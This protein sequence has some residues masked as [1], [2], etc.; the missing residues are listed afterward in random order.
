MNSYQEIS[1]V[2]NEEEDGFE[3]CIEAYIVGTEKENLKNFLASNMNDDGSFYTIVKN[4]INSIMVV[5]NLDVDEAYRGQGWGNSILESIISEKQVD[6]I[7]LIADMY[8]TQS[9]GFNLVKF[10]EKNGFMKV[11]THLDCPVMIYP[12]E[13]AAK[14]KHEVNELE[15]S[16]QNKVKFK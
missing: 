10:Y 9:P 3:G 13:V 11:T 7:I 12:V 1:Q 8:E 2:Y 6:G 16:I 5:K 4:N 15:K 14:I